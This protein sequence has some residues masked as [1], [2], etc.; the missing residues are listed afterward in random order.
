MRPKVYGKRNVQTKLTPDAMEWL[1]RTAA[2][3]AVSV[4]ECLRGIVETARHNGTPIAVPVHGSL[5]S[6]QVG[7]IRRSAKTGH[8]FAPQ[9]G[10]ALRC[11][12]CGQRKAAH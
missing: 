11:S 9:P 7:M 4:S 8:P 1:E 10:N 2:D 12:E 5:A 3:L 6:G